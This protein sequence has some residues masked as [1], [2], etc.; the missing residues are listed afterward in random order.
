MNFTHSLVA[1]LSSKHLL[2]HP[3]Y[4]A[5]SDG[6]LPADA[7]KAYAGQYYH[8]VTA[9]PRYVSATHSQCEDLAQRQFLLENLNDEEAGD[10]NHPELWARFAEGVGIARDELERQP[11]APATRALVD[12]FLGAARESFET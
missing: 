9:F 5:W 7:L 3:F 2:K 8:H 10:E 6:T 11:A 12:T 4:Q 1:A